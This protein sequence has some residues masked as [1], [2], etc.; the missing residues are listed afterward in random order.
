M[1]HTRVRGIL[2]GLLPL[3]IAAPARA[4]APRITADGDPSV[5]ADTIYALAVDPTDYPEADDVLLLD[6]GVVVLQ[7]D[8]TAT[9]T[10]R[11]VAQ[12]LTRDGVEG[13][14]ERT[15]G[16]DGSSQ[17]LRVNWVKVV[18]PD[19]T[20]VSDEPAHRQLMDAPVAQQSPIFTDRKRL[21]LSLAGV[22]PGTIVDFSYTLVTREARRP[23]D[24]LG[25]WTITPAATVRRSRYLV[26]VP[27][28]MNLAVDASPFT[29]D[30]TVTV[31]GGRKVYDWSAAD[32]EP[33]EPEAFEVRRERKGFQSLSIATPSSWADIGAWYASLA[34][35]RYE[36]PNDVL[37]AAA[38]AVGDATGMDALRALHRWV[39]QDFRYVSIS[40]GI[41]GY[42]PRLPAE[43]LR[44]K[45]G[46]CKDK[47]TLFV[48]LARHYGF[49]AE[50]VL[51]SSTG[52]AEEDL[53]SIQ[54]FDHAIAAVRID[55][56]WTYVD[57][58]ADVVPFG[59]VP[60]SYQGG[61]GLIVF[62]DGSVEET[63]F[64]QAPAE[65]N[66]THTIVQ[67]ELFADGS[68]EGGFTQLYRGAP[69]YPVRSTFARDFTPDQL[70]QIAQAGAQLI[71]GG[72]GADLDIFNGLD[73]DSAAH[74]SLKI[75]SDAATRRNVGGGQIF[76]LPLDSHANPGLVSK[77]ED[78]IP[79]RTAPIDIDAVVGPVSSISELDL[80]LPEGWV[81]QLPDDVVADS[82]FGTYEARYH[83][84]GRNVTVM[85]RLT[86]A[87]G[88]APAA[89]FPDLVSWLR[90]MA[91]DDA[92][93]LLLQPPA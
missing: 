93:F 58:T 30:P 36:L 82:R 51:L 18:K 74:I 12:I 62:D 52:S 67:G 35:D 27:G 72:K 34:D 31:Q 28:D 21:R 7:A 13:W 53:P 46:D 6:D 55:G 59:R 81:A 64:P 16:Y 90:E 41:G 38:A 20:V 32:L 79:T 76:I 91:K 25:Y 9:E 86:G 83:Q 33:L 43:V 80:T 5:L 3:A 60:P 61:F 66:F 92:I 39:A 22:E 37:A 89:A 1:T 8:G 85:R 44:T 68:F 77:L 17:D 10:Y 19:G 84:E 45:S 15:L 63:T 78:E 23:G 26:D 11:S 42:Q 87:R 29:M 4:Q 47:A 56:E 49:E 50:P 48:A 24:F 75:T 40:L 54:Q 69:E 65:D 73:L 88:T 71:E 57:L 14:A 2:F 70:D